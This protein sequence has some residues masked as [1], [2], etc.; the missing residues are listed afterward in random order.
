MHNVGQLLI[1]YDNMSSVLGS[2]K[3]DSCNQWKISEIDSAFVFGLQMC[4]LPFHCTIIPNSDSIFTSN[5]NLYYTLRH[6]RRIAVLLSYH[7]RMPCQKR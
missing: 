3:H 1:K 5:H 6:R 7:Q 2:I 4:Q